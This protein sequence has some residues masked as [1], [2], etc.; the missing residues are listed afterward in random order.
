MGVTEASERWAILGPG[1][2]SLLDDAVGAFVLLDADGVIVDWNRAAQATFGWTRAQ[3]VGA[4]AVELLV[5]RDLRD[6]LHV[7]FG[8]LVASDRRGPSPPV[9]LRAVHRDG[10]EMPM[11]LVLSTV[12]T[13]G[14]W[15]VAAFLYD[16]SERNRTMAGLA[17]ANSRFAG[18]F[19]AASIGMALTGLDGRFLEVNPAL[20]KLLAR[21]ADTLLASSF[22]D[23]THPDDLAGSLHELQRARSGE[24]DTFQQSKRY[25]LPDG[26]IV[27]GLLTLTIVRDTGGCPRHFVA[28][29]QDITA[30]KTSEGE[31]RRYAA[32]LESLSEHDPLTGLSN[33]RA[34]EVALA[35]ELRLV[36]AGSVACTVL[37]VRVPGGD[38]AVMAAAAAL[39]RVSRDT[40]LVAR[41]GQEGEL[42][43]LLRGIDTDTV[44]AIAQRAREA[45]DVCSE[46]RFSH[47]TAGGGESVGRLMNTLREGLSGPEPAQ[48]THGGDTLPVGIGR[49]LELARHQLGMPVSFLARLHGDGYVFARF[50]GDA[51]QFGVAE[52]DA[53]PL[54]GTHCQRMLDGRCGS[55][56]ADAEADPETRALAVTTTLGVRAYAGVPVR[57]RTGEIY[58]T[59]CAVDTQPH[60]GLGER[61]TEL[62]TFLSEL[63]A[64]LIE[65]EAE[66]RAA[67]RAEAGVAGVRTLLAALEARDFYTGEH[68]KW[69][70]AFASSVARNLG[71]DQDSVRDVEQVALLHDIGKVGIPD[72]ILQ[73]QGPLD[74]Q[75]WQLMRQHP[76]VGERIIAGTPGLSHLAPAMRAE[77][78]RWDG[79]G[80]PDGL[81]REEIP[82]A[83]RITLA[84]DALHAMTSDRP[85]R[86]A[87]TQQRARQELRDGAGSQFDPRVIK[88]LLAEIEASQT[89]AEIEASQPPADS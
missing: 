28:Q 77:H 76:V 13:G 70:V 51:E 35:A 71:L 16:V 63:A 22:Q 72:A 88:A 66:R 49:L 17:L 26:G 7:A 42:A 79:G 1:L 23:V 37:L 85:Y 89:P 83:S 56:I 39:R 47:A 60:P 87:M 9:E 44:G 54:A 25:L 6:E 84:C 2:G 30:R 68:S 55:I 53:M 75:E 10:R 74:A 4:E 59:L 52:G 38:S 73:K 48:P 86:P 46:V 45:L 21:D 57:L 29:I 50:A 24:I 8:R 62:M 31:L 78:E 36:E 61:D 64:E 12:D 81:A 5:A 15:L 82:V 3:A 40:D 32:Q 33:Q 41:L 18:A 20:C 27:W 65:H 69:V 67:R 58:G 34:F 14:R 43:M 11:E 80:Y 19:A